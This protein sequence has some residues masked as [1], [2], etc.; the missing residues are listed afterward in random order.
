MNLIKHHTNQKKTDVAWLPTVPEHWDTLRGRHIFRI[1]KRIA[2]KL[3]FDVL[4][5]TQKGIKQ[6]DLTPGE[7]QLSMDYSKYQHVFVG[8]FVMNHMDLLTGWV[9]RSPFDGVTSPDYRVF[10]IIDDDCDPGFYTLVCQTGYLQKL[11]YAYGQGVSHL[12]RWRFPAD[13][14]KNFVFPK[15]PLSEQKLISARVDRETAR[16]DALI[17]KKTR[18]IELLKEKRQALITQAVTKGLDPN[19]PMRDSG[20]EWIGEVPEGWS[21]RPFKRLAKIQNGRD[22]KEVAAADGGYPV[23][24][25]GGEFARAKRPLFTGE[26]VLLG[27]KGTIDKP[28]YINGSFWPVDTMFYTLINVQADGRFVYYLAKTI[29]FSYYSSSTALPSMTQEDLSTHTVC[30]PDKKGQEAISTYLDGQTS[31]IDLLIEKS[32]SSIDL[33][34]ERRS[35]LITAAVTGQIDLREAA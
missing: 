30:A 5:V 26:S 3:G 33:L 7:G 1:Q 35:A 17:E 29:P 2:G 22:Y 27:R 28:L 31:R 19:V 21:L 34:K 18:F 4:A 25:S 9:D 11:F 14:F 20:V 10:E 32:L 12:G 23:I 24:G 16:I 8:D 13:N 15:P 6:K